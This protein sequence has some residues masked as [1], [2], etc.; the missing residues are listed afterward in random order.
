MASSAVVAARAGQ[1][2]RD[3]KTNGELGIISKVS[4]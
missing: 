3:V 2:I 4:G 1:I